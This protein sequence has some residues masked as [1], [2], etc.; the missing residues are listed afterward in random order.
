MRQF[1]N[2]LT[3][4]LIDVLLP[5]GGGSSSAANVTLTDNGNGTV[6]MAN[7]LVSMTFSKSDG[8]VSSFYLAGLPT[9]NLIDYSQDYALSLTHIGSGT[10]VYWS[11]INSP[12]IPTYMVVTNQFDADGNFNS[13]V[14]MNTNAPQNFCLLQLP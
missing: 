9:T 13:N 3:A 2:A 11:S 10:N 4:G 5:P 6:T 12:G 1:A 7:G 8:S 14:V